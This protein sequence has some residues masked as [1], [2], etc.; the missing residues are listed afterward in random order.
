MPFLEAHYHPFLFAMMTLSGMAELGLTSFLI[1][2]GNENGTWPSPRYHSLLIM[3]C[4][5][6]AWT[7]L[8]STTYMLWYVDGASHFLANVA[9]SVI[10][11]L[12][13]SAL[14][15]TAAGIMHNTRSGGDCARRATISRCRQSL[16]VE[17]LGWTEFGLCALTLIATCLWVHSSSW[18]RRQHCDGASD[19]QRLV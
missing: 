3:F 15:G 19:S 6:A 10:W 9:S 18:R 17:A 13:T 2:A 8:F 12:V 16:T 11:L 14:W 4:F 1:S 7:T 5:N